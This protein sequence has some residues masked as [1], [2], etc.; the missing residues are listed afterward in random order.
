MKM[1]NGLFRSEPPGSG[2]LAPGLRP[3]HSQGYRLARCFSALSNR[4]PP[5]SFFFQQLSGSIGKQKTPFSYASAMEYS[6]RQDSAY[7]LLYCRFLAV[8]AVQHWVLVCRVSL[9]GS[10]RFCLDQDQIPI[11]KC[12]SGLAPDREVAI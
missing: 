1:S 3:E 4:L 6:I 5:A 11:D 8:A 10:G 9:I 2:P 7:S 12:D